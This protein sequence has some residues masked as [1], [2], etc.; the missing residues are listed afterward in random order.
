MLMLLILHGDETHDINITLKR[1]SY[2][3]LPIPPYMC[4][5][6]QTHTHR[7]DTHLFLFLSHLF[8]SDAWVDNLSHEEDVPRVVVPD[9]DDERTVELEDGDSSEGQQGDLH[10]GGGGGRGPCL[11]HVQRCLVHHLQE[12]TSSHQR[13]AGHNAVSRLIVLMRT[14]VIHL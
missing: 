5:T 10:P 9:E 3:I 11:V 4:L 7:F 12:D 6:T 2:Y 14:N 8:S 1:Q 13:E